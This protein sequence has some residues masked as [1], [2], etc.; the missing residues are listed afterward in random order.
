MSRIRVVCI[1]QSHGDEHHVWPLRRPHQEGPAV[2]I[3]DT[4]R[5][6][7]VVPNISHLKRKRLMSLFLNFCSNTS[8]SLKCNFILHTTFSSASL[9]CSYWLLQDFMMFKEYFTDLVG[10]LKSPVITIKIPQQNNC[11]LLHSCPHLHKEI[12]EKLF[13]KCASWS[14]NLIYFLVQAICKELH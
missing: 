11:D 14:L 8:S 2:S 9:S 1:Y 4:L 7:T 13:I 10:N 12:P 3:L 6:E 5:F